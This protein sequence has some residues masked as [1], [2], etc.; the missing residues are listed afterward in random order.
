MNLVQRHASRK[1]TNPCITIVEG[2]IALAIAL[3]HN[4]K[5]EGYVVESID[6][7]DESRTRAR[8]RASRSCHSRLDVVR[9]VRLRNLFPVALGVC[10]G[11]TGPG[12]AHLVA[13]LYE[14]RNDHA[15]VLA[16]S[17]QMPR[18][19]TRHRLFSNDKSRYAVS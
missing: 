6:R 17:G 16:L 5:T 11:T 13:G 4:L 2:D 12:S 15:P 18:Q 19:F 10:C 3:S 7:G 9:H 8:W 1:M 14:A